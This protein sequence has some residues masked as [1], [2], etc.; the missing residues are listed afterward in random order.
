MIGGVAGGIAEYFDIDPVIIRAIFIISLL[1]WGMS[2]IVYIV[3]WIIVPDESKIISKNEIFSSIDNDED[4]Q[5]FSSKYQTTSSS[6]DNDKKKNIKNHR[7]EARKIFGG[8]ILIVFGIVLLLDNILQYSVFE[9][10]W[11]VVLIIF[12]IFILMR[13]RNFHNFLNKQ[14]Q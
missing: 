11:P 9:Q 1:G 4:E 8:V 13:N 6:F 7:S 14:N 10:F 12:G 2:L 3:L 5:E